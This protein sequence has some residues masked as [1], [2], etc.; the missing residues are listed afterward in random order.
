MLSEVREAQQRSS[1]AEII[2]E[3]VT[4]SYGSP[5]LSPLTT[6]RVSWVF[7]SSL[8][9]SWFSDSWLRSKK[10]LPLILQQLCPE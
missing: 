5:P 3:S 10:N 2:Q 9:A 1:L 4:A 8:L 7:F 6:R